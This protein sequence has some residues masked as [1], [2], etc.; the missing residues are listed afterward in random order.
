MSL[1]ALFTS[2]SVCMFK[3]FLFHRALSSLTCV[4]QV[5]RVA[6][7][8]AA[9]GKHTAPWTAQF[10]HLSIH[11][12]RNIQRNPFPFVL[13][14]ITAVR[15]QYLPSIARKFFFAKNIK[16]NNDAHT[17]ATIR[18]SLTSSSLSP[19]FSSFVYHVFGT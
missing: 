18:V 7:L 2:R 17:H 14:G 1:T 11:T 9:R 6:R 10:M 5:V 4:Q 13:H 3:S 15:L 8:L 16:F 12:L 19:F